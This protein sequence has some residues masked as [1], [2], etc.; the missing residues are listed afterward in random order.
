MLITRQQRRLLEK[1]LIK[2]KK[3]KKEIG[4]KLCK[5]LI[6]CYEGERFLASICA[7]GEYGTYANYDSP[8]GWSAQKE[9][10]LL[11]AGLGPISFP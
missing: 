1:I 6:L 5:M 3:R 8:D 11:K 9:V 7:P 2:I 4:F 10:L